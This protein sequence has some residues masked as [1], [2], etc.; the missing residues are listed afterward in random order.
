MQIIRQETFLLEFFLQV[1]NQLPQQFL[2]PVR[3]FSSS[4]Q[5]I[6]ENIEKKF[7]N[8]L[9]KAVEKPVAK[10]VADKGLVFEFSMFWVITAWKEIGIGFIRNTFYTFRPVIMFFV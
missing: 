6:A 5:E 10:E 4:H 3:S 9:S 2:A 8:E 1:L 7:S